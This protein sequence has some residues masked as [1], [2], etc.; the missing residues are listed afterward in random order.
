MFN[1]FLSHINSKKYFQKSDKILIAVSG[2][3]DSMVLL[4]LLMKSDYDISVAHLNHKTRSGDS[5]LDAEFVKSFCLKHNIPFYEK[6]LSEK[7]SD[8][9]NFQAW[10][11]DQR[12]TFFESLDCDIILTAHH[13]DDHIETVLLNIF[14]GRS[15]NGIH[16]SFDKIRRPLL[17]FTKDEITDYAQNNEVPFV[18]DK[19]NKDSEYDRNFIRNELL[20]KIVERF[21]NAL[22]RIK[23]LSSRNQA[24]QQALQELVDRLDLE[25]REGS[26]II[27]SKIKIQE[28]DDHL[29]YH[30][31]KTKGFNQTHAQDIFRS[32]DNVGAHFES[33]SHQLIIDR[34]N[35]IIEEITDVQEELVIDLSQIEKYYIYNNFRFTLSKEDQLSQSTEPN[36]EY[37]PIALLTEGLSIRPWKD[38]DHFQPKGMGGHRQ[39]LKKFYTNNKI[40]LLQKKKVPL[41]I[42][43]KE[44]I[45]VVPYRT[46][47]RYSHEN[48]EG[49]YLKIQFE[50]L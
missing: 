22:N 16:E 19:S 47:E 12:Y 8:V 42:S 31:L 27:I 3:V 9:S 7:K 50:R 1:R 29:L 17:I 37:F 36:S 35:L 44:I 23:K 24:D 4:D 25:I 6:E 11:H 49:P 41:F 18:V 30:I 34:K 39:S 2:G 15:M 32:I 45:W 21:P 33:S 14:N 5:D 10:A 28:L 48:Q 43:G 46:D 26:R 13:L 38:G 20:S 40:D